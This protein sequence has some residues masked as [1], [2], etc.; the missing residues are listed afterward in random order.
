MSATANNEYT[1]AQEENKHSMTICN[2]EIQQ[3]RS[4]D[5]HTLLL[6]CSRL[7]TTCHISHNILWLPEN[8]CQL[9]NPP[10]TI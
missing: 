1:K 9:D 2:D 8:R 5:Q 10:D 3:L 6:D 7:S 4:N